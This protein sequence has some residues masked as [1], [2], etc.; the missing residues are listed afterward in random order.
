MQTQAGHIP[1]YITNSVNYTTKQDDTCS[2]TTDPTKNPL[3][4]EYTDPCT[5]TL[6]GHDSSTTKFKSVLSWKQLD[7][8][9]QTVLPNDSKY[10]YVIEDFQPKISQNFERAPMNC[11]EALIRINLANEK[12]TK[13]WIQDMMAHSLTTYRITRTTTPASKRIV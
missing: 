13:Q 5:S 3:P 10:M 6:P 1:K 12:E 9:L 8:P 4:Q 11:F 2:S 7:V